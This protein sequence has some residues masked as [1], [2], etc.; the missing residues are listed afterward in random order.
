MLAP[1]AQNHAR[2]QYEFHGID[3]VLFF[4]TFFVCE[5]ATHTSSGQEESNCLNTSRADKG[6]PTV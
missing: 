2:F 4:G 1:I 5:Q 6:N 3:R